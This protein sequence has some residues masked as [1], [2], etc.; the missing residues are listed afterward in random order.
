MLS[1]NKNVT[2]NSQP[3]WFSITHYSNQQII[4]ELSIKS[5]NPTLEKISK[6]DK[7]K[8]K[9][10]Q[11]RLLPDKSQVK[12]LKSQMNLFA[13]YYNAS[14]S[15]LFH[16][17]QN[18]QSI[19]VEEK[20]EFSYAK[21]RELL[22]Y[23]KYNPDIPEKFSRR[24]ENEGKKYPIPPGI[25]EKNVHN[26]LRRG[27]VKMFINA[28][29]S[30]YVLHEG[31][32]TKFEFKFKT[33]KAGTKNL[34][35]FEDDS[36]PKWINAIKGY[37][38]NSKHKKISWKRVQ[39]L[40]KTRSITIKYDELTKRLYLYWPVD[41]SVIESQ[42]SIFFRPKLTQN[43]FNKCKVIAIDPGIRTFSTVYGSN[44]SI[45]EICTE[46][47]IMYKYHKKILEL[48][49][50]LDKQPHKGKRKIIY[51]NRKTY[52]NKLIYRKI[53]KINK[54]MRNK[55]DDLHWKTINTLDK[56]GE[57]ILYPR[58]NVQQ[59]LKQNKFPDSVK[60][61]MSSLSFYKFKS[62]LKNKL[63]E[64]VRIIS[65]KKSTKTCC[66]CGE[67]DHNVRANHV[68]NCKHCHYT[69][70]RDW[71]G[72]INILHMNITLNKSK[73]LRGTTAP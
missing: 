68:Y 9:M 31:D 39:E 17:K 4:P 51:K 41:K 1:N 32:L 2:D 69:I 73:V 72:A 21:A 20:D 33:K 27:A 30:N 15:I 57:T 34:L 55:V 46:N 36:Y 44:D 70:N 11:I 47:T 8:Y 62:R 25:N 42:D 12:D 71:N 18:L 65:E 22:Y 50:K 37:Y 14:I 58:F 16:N 63:G 53:R 19:K 52:K 67:V 28:L 23:Y 64:R 56:L 60:R 24:E 59:M 35:Y 29:N 43:T 66:R 26:R 48:K 13:W 10:L 5:I 6:A 3:S 40:T 61:V 38:S 49:K 7:S 54:K 45:T